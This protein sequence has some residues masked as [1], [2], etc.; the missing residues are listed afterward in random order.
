MYFSRDEYLDKETIVECT[1][2][3]LLGNPI[4]EMSRL[5]NCCAARSR[6]RKRSIGK[7]AKQKK[8]KEH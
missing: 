3:L 6:I 7:R 1:G 8:K 5:S 4:L 2:L